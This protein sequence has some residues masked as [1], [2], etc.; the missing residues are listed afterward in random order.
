MGQK[1]LFKNSIYKALLSF[2]NIVIPIIIGP[3][4]TKLLNVELYGAY[5]KVYAEFQ[6][7]LIFATFG[8]YTFGVREISKIRDN[9]E[10]LSE[11]FSNLFL[12]G[13]ITNTITG[14]VYVIYSIISSNGVTQHIYLVFVIQIV[15]NIFYVEFLNEA[16]ENY[17]F[18]TIKTLIVK[19]LYLVLLL[20]CVKKPDDIIIYSIIISGIVFLNNIISYIYVRKHIP[21]SF[22][23][24]HFAKYVKPLFLVLIITN[25]EILYSQLDRIMLGKFV[26]DVSVTMYYIPYYL[27]STLASIPYA[28]INVSIPRL[29]YM[30]EVK[31]KQDY[32][33]ALNTA[34]TSVL[35]IILPMCAGVAI[36]A[37]E[38]VFIYAGDKYSNIFGIL[39]LAC[40]T[41]I[42]ISMESIM[43]NL[44]LYANNK[45]KK[46]VQFSFIFGLF[47]LTMN[48]ILVMLNKLS[49]F[50]AMLTTGIA[51]LLLV[52]TQYIYIKYKMRINI[53][54][55]TK[56]NVLYAF[57]S[58][59]FIP[60]SLIIHFINF[61]YYTNIILIII[62]CVLMYSGVLLLIKD[63]TIVMILNKFFGKFIKKKEKMEG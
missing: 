57:L 30:V 24:M 62:I 59:L 36:L 21:F 14:I 23:N 45:E 50:S 28:I 58:L 44:V 17:R 12:L 20:T 48:S 2:A 18:I 9:K 8:I 29:S 26:N 7:F 46:L 41:R 33:M 19:I 35:F 60:I 53:N 1:S 63:S 37:K 61:G 5:N 11:L 39:I 55:F 56:Q 51:E 47:N 34:I 43:T 40:I 10:K 49:P 31:G 27:I 16:L 22:K 3:Y 6:V 42:I 15:A 38:V 54:L 25:V 4:I 52:T 32:E 13:I